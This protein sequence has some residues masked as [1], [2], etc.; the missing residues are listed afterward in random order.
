[1]KMRITCDNSTHVCCLQGRVSSHGEAD[2]EAV[3][4]VRAHAAVLWLLHPARRPGR[5]GIISCYLRLSSGGITATGSII[6]MLGTAGIRALYIL[7][8]SQ[9]ASA[10]AG[11]TDACYDIPTDLPEHAGHYV[12][13]LQWCAEHIS[14]A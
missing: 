4:A 13:F 11:L 8:W 6:H 10:T 1:M 7:L 9:E 5:C 12:T 14:R 3:A 2:V